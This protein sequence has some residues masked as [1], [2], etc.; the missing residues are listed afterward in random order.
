MREAKTGVN[1]WKKASIKAGDDGEGPG[2]GLAL[3]IDPRYPGYEC[4]VFGASIRGLFD[5]KGNLITE[6]NP[7]SCNMGI[8]WDGDVLGE[9]LDGTRIDKWV[10]DSSKVSNLL[11]AGK[12]NCIKNNGTKSNPVLSG[13][14]LGDWREEV[15]WRTAD[16]K[17]LRIFSTTIATD[18]KFYTL[19]HDPQYRLSIAWQNVAYNQPPHTS[20]YI[21]E[22]MKNPPRPNIVVNSAQSK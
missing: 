22:G 11:E 8:Y 13:D 5:A 15:I 14:I 2:R 7:P 10:Y 17:E 9:L 21:G 20:F 19:M 4:W 18:K 16:N 12:F 6:K 3:D 1:L